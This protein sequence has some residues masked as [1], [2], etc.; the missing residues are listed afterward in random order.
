MLY[1]QEATVLAQLSLPRGVRSF[2][3]RDL[4]TVQGNFAYCA[5]TRFAVLLTVSETERG[6]KGRAGKG[7][8]TEG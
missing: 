4:S 5:P 3:E 1:E 2:L 6:E 8:E 7:I